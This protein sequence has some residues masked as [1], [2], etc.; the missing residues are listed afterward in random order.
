MEKM[1]WREKVQGHIGGF[2]ENLGGNLSTTTKRAHE[3]VKKA[4]S[5]KKE[6]DKPN[7]NS[8][9]DMKLPISSQATHLRYMATNLENERNQ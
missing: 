9:P 3:Y 8:E 1:L 4:N 2:C 5:E 6:K 7:I